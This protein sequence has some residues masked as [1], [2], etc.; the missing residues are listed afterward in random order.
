MEIRPFCSA[1]V[2]NIAG[3]IMSGLGNS[4][5]GTSKRSESLAYKY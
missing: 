4:R 3:L 1:A 5:G 2:M